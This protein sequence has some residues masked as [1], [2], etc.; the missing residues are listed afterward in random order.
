MAQKPGLAPLAHQRAATRVGVGRVDVLKA[1][2]RPGIQFRAPAAW[3]RHAMATASS[4]VLPPGNPSW[5]LRRTEIG[6]SAGQAAR[7]ASNTCSGKRARFATLPPYS[8][9]RAFVSGDRK[10]DI[11]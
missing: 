3:N 5:Q 11:R 6:R 8:S 7:T 1:Q 10:L 2:A 4:A 9:V